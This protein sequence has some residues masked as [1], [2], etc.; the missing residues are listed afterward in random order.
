MAQL[1][2]FN[3]NADFDS[4]GVN[5]GDFR[6]KLESELSKFKERFKATFP[7]IEITGTTF[8]NCSL[9]IEVPDDQAKDLKTE[10]EGKLD[11]QVNTPFTIQPS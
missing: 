11:C 10:I 3:H 9:F 4:S 2:V 6:T 7:D 8:L 5:K 1:V